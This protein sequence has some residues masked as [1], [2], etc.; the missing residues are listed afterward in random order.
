MKYLTQVYS[1]EIDP[2]NL[3]YYVSLTNYYSDSSIE[4][5]EGVWGNTITYELDSLKSDYY[6]CLDTLYSDL[7]TEEDKL[8]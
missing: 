3:D 6:G 8:Y 7:Q 4:T 2:I 5:A 1:N